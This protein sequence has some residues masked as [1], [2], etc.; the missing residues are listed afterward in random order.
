MASI[1]TVVRVQIT[2]GTRQVPLAGFGIPLIVGASNRFVDAVR[3]YTDPADMLADGFL[4]SDPE[5]IHAVSLMSQSVQPES[6]LIGKNTAPVA[7]VNNITITSVVNSFAY[8]VT[9]NGTPYTYTS[10]GSATGAE[11]QAGLVAAINNV[12]V[13][14]S[15]GSG[16][17]VNVTSEEAGLGFSISVGANLAFTLTTANHSIADDIATIQ[18][19]N[20]TWYGL[21]ITSKVASNILQVAAYIQ[22]QKKIFIAASADS[23][24][25]STSALDVASLLQDKNYDRTALIYSAQASL[26]PD[27]AWLG[28]MLPTGVGSAT[29]KFKTLVGITADNLSATEVANVAAK[30]GNVF[31]TVGGIDITSEGVMASGEFIDVT[32]FIDWLVATMEA[33]VYSLLINSDKVPYTNKGIATVEN[34]VRQ[35]LQAGIDNG[36]LSNTPAPTVSVPDVLN[37]SQADKASRTLN[38]VIF[39]ATLAGAIHKIN[40]QGFVSV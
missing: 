38:N 34:A 18:E 19:T 40:I 10:D 22:T 11:I 32:R 14:T 21:A 12:N 28:R 25:I 23:N 35:T 9:I 7:Q 3:V 6:F 8:V 4:S 24:V 29:W 2:K 1:E 36:G 15:P 39:T 33:A 17:S 26:G 16:T 13:G 5:Y 27:A 31:I 37:V 20:D 30:S